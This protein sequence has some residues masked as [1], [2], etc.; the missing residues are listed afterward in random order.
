[1]T[2]NC[3]WLRRFVPVLAVVLLG[4][5]GVSHAQDARTQIEQ[6]LSRVERAAR[7]ASIPKEY[8]DEG[9]PRVLSGLA[10]ARRD[11]E[12]NR[13][14]LALEEFLA[15]SM[16][17]RALEFLAAN[18]EAAKKGMPAFEA[19][20]SRADLELRDLE[21]RYRGGNWASMPAALRALAEGS[22]GQARPLYQASRGFAMTS[23]DTGFYYLGDSKAALE[24]AL[25]CQSLRFPPTPQSRGSRSSAPEIRR[26]EEK[27]LAA[28]KPPQSIDRHSG[29][30][31]INGTL[32]AAGELDEAQLYDGA[33]YK[34]LQALRVFA[35][36]DARAPEADRA[37][38]FREE[39]SRLRA[40]LS[41]ATADD[42][43]VQ[44]LLER[45]ESAL[46]AA[47]GN[48]GAAGDPR[49]AQVLLKEVIPAYFA[50]VESAGG[51]VNSPA[52]TAQITVTLVRWP[53]T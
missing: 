6:E 16:D 47:G 34:Y 50:A 21:Q 2:V 15:A 35:L 22:F 42:S 19:E 39:I 8:W 10:S 9:K 44:L 32:K 18:W 24:A 28:Y 7:T 27:V 52:A 31:R 53:Y 30:I 25:F 14:Y 46:D 43:I 48:S 20:W 45:A 13:L 5:P 40:R 29:F 17:L 26:L 38:D 4:L 12:A 49:T 36:L 37:K 51:A 41:S 1:M 33:L 11:L 23:P 3:G